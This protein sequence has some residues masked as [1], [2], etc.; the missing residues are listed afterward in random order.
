MI[1]LGIWTERAANTA[2]ALLLGGF[3]LAVTINMLAA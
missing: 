2:T 3:V 1:N